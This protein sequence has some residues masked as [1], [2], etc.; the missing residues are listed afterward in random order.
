MYD[1][2]AA[3]GTREKIFAG[4][5]EQSNPLLQTLLADRFRLNVHGEMR[6]TSVYA[7]IL[8]KHGPKFKENVEVREPGINT[9]KGSGGAHMNG[10]VKRE[11]GRAEFMLKPVNEL[12]IA[13]NGWGCVRYSVGR[14]GASP[15]CG[16]LRRGVPV[17]ISFCG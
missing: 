8:D 1:I 13:G 4:P 7:L 17:S 15:V 14:L 9:Q 2:V 16:P 12:F 5:I 6:E 3:T 10:T 11:C